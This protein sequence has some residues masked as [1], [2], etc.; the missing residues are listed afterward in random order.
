M[1]QKKVIIKLLDEAKE[2]Y[3]K[4]KETVKGEKEKGIS[5]SFSQT[6]LRSID[7]KIE[8]LK[9]RC[10]YGIQIPRKCIP[11]E[12]VREYGVTNLWKVD[13]SGGWRMVYTLRQPLRD[14][15]EIEIISILLDVLCIS[16]HGK[17]DDVFGYKKR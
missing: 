8:V 2:E 4:L 16:D 14:F 13:L 9:T 15:E 6:L 7:S 17:Y 5:S 11:K 10:D 3:L 1:V 12:Y